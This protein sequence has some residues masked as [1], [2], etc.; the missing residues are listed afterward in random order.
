VPG[1]PENGIFPPLAVKIT[2]FLMPLTALLRS[3]L[4]NKAA[5]PEKFFPEGKPGLPLP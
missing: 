4:N 1:S 3:F 2:V 5:V